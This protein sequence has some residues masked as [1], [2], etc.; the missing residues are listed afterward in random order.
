[1]PKGQ[2]IFT[3]EY[4]INL[5]HYPDNIS[6]EECV[7]I[8]VENAEMDPYIFLDM[9]KVSIVGNVVKELEDA[10]SDST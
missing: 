2:I 1:M 4:D 9:E 3:V 8:D 6:L 5:D 10:G 7:Q